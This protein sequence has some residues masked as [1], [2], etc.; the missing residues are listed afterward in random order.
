MT[1]KADRF[2]LEEKIMGCWSII[3]DMDHIKETKDLEL[4]T[5]IQELYSAKFN[6]LFKVFEDLVH[7]GTIK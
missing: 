4:V 6:S 3:E 5:H 1:K 2:T 7:D